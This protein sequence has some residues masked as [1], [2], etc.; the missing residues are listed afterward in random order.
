MPGSGLGMP[1]VPTTGRASWPARGRPTTA[2]PASEGLEGPRD[3]TSTPLL[4]FVAGER[5]HKIKG[6]EGLQPRFRVRS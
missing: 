4:Q 6:L 3:C 1:R 2:L 5:E